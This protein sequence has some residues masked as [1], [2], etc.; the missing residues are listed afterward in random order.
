[1]PVPVRLSPVVIF[2][3]KF[4]FPVIRVCVFGEK[5][6]LTFQYPLCVAM[7]DVHNEE[8]NYQIFPFEKCFSS[9]FCLPIVVDGFF[10]S[11]R[12]VFEWSLTLLT[13]EVFTR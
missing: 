9:V 3:R 4:N 12:P 7:C 2:V 10:F 8:R 6:S 1:M 5:V 13:L 11:P